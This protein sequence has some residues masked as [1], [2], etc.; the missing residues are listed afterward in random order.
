MAE[1]RFVSETNHT[2]TA[3]HVSAEGSAGIYGVYVSALICQLLNWLV[4]CVGPPGCLRDD[5]W[6]WRNLLVSWLHALVCVVWCLIRCTSTFYISL[7]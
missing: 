2:M 4:K 6:K 1:T 7:K 3:T 5:E